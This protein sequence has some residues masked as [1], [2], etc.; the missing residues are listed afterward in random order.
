MA[1]RKKRPRVLDA[2]RADVSRAL[3]RVLSIASLL[4][5]LGSVLCGSSLVALHEEGVPIAFGRRPSVAF[6]VPAP[7]VSSTPWLMGLGGLALVIAGTGTA[8]VGLRRILADERYVILRSD[9]A[10]FVRG[11][12]RRVVKWRNVEDVGH[13]DG[14]LVFHCH[15]GTALTIGGEWGGVT[16]PELARRVAQVRRRALLG[17]TGR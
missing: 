9:G 5:L 1:K 15:D 14:A 6:V 12:E 3:A 7:P 13:E 16:V 2:Y 10:L 8:I 4:V 11:R 17:L